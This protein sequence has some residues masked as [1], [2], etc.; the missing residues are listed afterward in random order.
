MSNHDQP[1]KPEE[2]SSVDRR[3]LLRTLGAALATASAGGALLAETTAMP[4]AMAARK[5]VRTIPRDVKLSPV[6]GVYKVF[7]SRT[8][9]SHTASVLVVPTS[10]PNDVTRIAKDT[11]GSPALARVVGGVVHVDLGIAAE[12]RCTYSGA[13]AAA[14][15]NPGGDP[16]RIIG[17]I[18]RQ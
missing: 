9:S 1:K 10:S 8:K 3:E 12:G 4:E 14:R 17:P 18:T 5:Y 6:D 11:G 2:T 7:Y 15:F 16:E 13:I